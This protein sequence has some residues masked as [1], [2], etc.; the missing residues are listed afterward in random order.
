MPDEEQA[1]RFVRPI[2]IDWP[3]LAKGSLDDAYTVAAAAHPK[4]PEKEGHFPGGEEE[5]GSDE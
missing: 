3:G 5:E 4:I 1:R 2:P